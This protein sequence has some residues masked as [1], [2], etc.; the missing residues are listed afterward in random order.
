MITVGCRV[1]Y[2]REDSE[3]MRKT[4]WYPPIGTLGTVMEITE[5]AFRVQWDSGTRE[6]GIWYCAKKAVTL[7]NYYKGG[8]NA[9]ES[10]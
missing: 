7:P 6:D 3:L 4:G 9:N 2:V 8:R 1:R 5:D 10:N